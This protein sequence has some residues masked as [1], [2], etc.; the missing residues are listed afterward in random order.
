MALLVIVLAH[1]SPETLFMMPPVLGA[2]YA[3]YRGYVAA[4]HERDVWQQL[5]RRRASS[6]P[7]T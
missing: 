1:W 5:E 4:A 7:S 3:S 6:T 2:M